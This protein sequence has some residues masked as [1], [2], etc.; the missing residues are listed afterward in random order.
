ML[1]VR[2]FPEGPARVL[3]VQRACAAEEEHGVLQAGARVLR[4]VHCEELEGACG[5]SRKEQPRD[6]AC[7]HGDAGCFAEERRELGVRQV[8]EG[9]GYAVVKR[10][11]RHADYACPVACDKVRKEGLEVWI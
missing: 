1:E 2:V 7:V 3:D 4:D 6:V 11:L 8:F 5:E 9:Y 10:D